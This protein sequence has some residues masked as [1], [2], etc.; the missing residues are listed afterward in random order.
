VCP[1]QVHFRLFICMDI[2]VTLSFSKVM[3][4]RIL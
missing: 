4:I 3:N 2:S 1:I